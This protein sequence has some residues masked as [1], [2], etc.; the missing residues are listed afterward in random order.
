MLNE[1]GFS[2]DVSHDIRTLCRRIGAP[3]FVNNRKYRLVASGST[4]D[5][6]EFLLFFQD[7]YDSY[8]IVEIGSM[9]D[10]KNPLASHKLYVHPY[11]QEGKEAAWRLITALQN[12]GKKE[13]DGND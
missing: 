4:R 10:R 6:K 8:R 13:V 3:R 11:T 7:Y 1:F 12:C 5:L 9:W 2:S